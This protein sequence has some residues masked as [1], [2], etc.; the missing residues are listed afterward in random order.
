VP[1]TPSDFADLVK[2]IKSTE[3]LDRNSQLSKK[4]IVHQGDKPGHVS[5]NTAMATIN[6][7]FE[8]KCFEEAAALLGAVPCGDLHADAI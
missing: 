4:L 7:T 5:D 6:N 3:V 1:P 8:H 2:D